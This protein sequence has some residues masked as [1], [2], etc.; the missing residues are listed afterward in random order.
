MER[1]PREYIMI[2]TTY[3]KLLRNRRH[4]KCQLAYR[5]LSN[6]N[7]WRLIINNGQHTF[8]CDIDKSTDPGSEGKDFVDNRLNMANE[9]IIFIP[10]T[11]Q[12][13]N[14]A[15]KTNWIFGETNSLYV[16]NPTSGQVLGLSETKVDFDKDAEI[17]AND[18]LKMVIWKGI[19]TACPAFD[20]TNKVFTPYNNAAWAPGV[21]AGWAT[22]ST[23][24]DMDQMIK[25]HYLESQ[26][27]THYIY[28]D[29]AG[30]QQYM[31]V[32]HEF[33][34]IQDISIKNKMHIVLNKQEGEQ[35]YLRSIFLRS[36]YFE[37]IEIYPVQ[38]IPHF[39]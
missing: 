31:A 22:K 9:P 25:Q 1:I 16:I 15:D 30:N 3:E 29:I 2:E 27:V 6:K 4:Y 7:Q 38:L 37:R 20:N 19:N 32:V 11:V 33:N 5:N 18:C 35:K 34:T 28:L 23:L 39:V 14:F 13:H 10:E 21:S 8:Y 12:T 26:E 36:S 24:Q 17:P